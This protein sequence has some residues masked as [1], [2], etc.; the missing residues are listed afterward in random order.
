MLADSAFTVGDSCAVG[1]HCG[2]IHSNDPVGPNGHA[3]LYQYADAKPYRGKKFRLRSAVR[4]KVS[5]LPDGAGLL[6]RVHNTNNGTCFLDNMTDR[7][8]T[9]GEWAYYEITGPVCAEADNIEPGLQLRGSGVAWVDDVTL[10]FA[11]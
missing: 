7:R 2:T 3:F 4:A 8:V 1:E 11:K 6:A 10:V 9:S 5:G